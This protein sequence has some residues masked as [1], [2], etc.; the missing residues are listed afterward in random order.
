M[1]PSYQARVN[2]V[3]FCLKTSVRFG[4]QIDNTEL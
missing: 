1:C 4:L 3:V 2:A